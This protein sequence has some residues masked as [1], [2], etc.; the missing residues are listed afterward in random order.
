MGCSQAPKGYT[1]L[2]LDDKFPLPMFYEAL[3]KNMGPVIES[4]AGITGSGVRR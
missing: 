3:A 4:T 2:V 1:D